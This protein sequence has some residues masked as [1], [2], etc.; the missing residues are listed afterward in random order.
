MTRNTFLTLIFCCSLSVAAQTTLPTVA[1]A[2]ASGQDI[3]GE[4]AMRQPN[5]PSYEFFEKLLPPLRYV[6]CTFRHY[7][8]ALAAPRG[9]LKAR[10]VSNGSG[11]NL[12]SGLTTKAWH[13]YPLG[14]AF[15]V[16]DKDESFGS[17]LSRV[18]GPT[19]EKGYLPIVKIRYAVGNSKVEQEAF[20]PT[21]PPF[22]DHAA[23]FVRFSVTGDGEVPISATIL[24]KDADSVYAAPVDG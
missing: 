19:F 10:L 17:D 3:W 6:D 20:V 23:V 15:G 4:L 5:G 9:L 11:V 14:L 2:F 24:A 13:D 12:P 7:P 1:E 21:R 16:G 22:S 18:E 8:I